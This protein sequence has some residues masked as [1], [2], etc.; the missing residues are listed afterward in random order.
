MTTDP[1]TGRNKFV[2]RF[3]ID[4]GVCCLP[5]DTCH[6]N[7]TCPECEQLGG[8]CIPGV[9]NCAEVPG[10]CCLPDGMCAELSR[11]DCEAVGGV[12]VGPCTDCSDEFGACCLPDKTCSEMKEQ[13]CLDLNGTFAGPCTRCRD[14]LGACCLPSGD[15]AQMTGPDC[16][17]ASGTFFGPCTRCDNAPGAC[18]LPGRVCVMLNRTECE[19]QGGAYFGSCT[20]CSEPPGACCLPDG[21]CV[22]ATEPECEAMGGILQGPCILCTDDSIRG[23]C[24]LGDDPPIRTCE[25]ITRRQCAERGGEFQN[26]CQRCRHTPGRCC[27]DIGDCREVPRD[28]CPS[29]WMGG[30]TACFPK[31]CDFPLFR[32]QSPK[33]DVSEKQIVVRRGRPRQDRLTPRA[34]AKYIKAWLGPK[35]NAVAQAVRMG[36][37][38]ICPKAVE[39]QGELY[40]DSCGCGA[41]GDAR[42]RIKTAMLRATC[43]LRKWPVDFSVEVVMNK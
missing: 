27:F 16:I 9:D 36:T 42:L 2:G 37:C 11:A 38:E 30:C 40:C 5:D 29:G 22:F 34:I 4:I 7:I 35:V 8:R 12:F 3:G 43:P 23:A 33:R 17:A 32:P 6:E 41:R 24:C 21:R 25:Y 14:E 31:A 26:P 28:E 20:D 19:S 13:D 39:W 15:C 10:T 18:C 1:G